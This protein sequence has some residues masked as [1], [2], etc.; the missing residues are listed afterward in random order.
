MYIEDSIRNIMQKLDV[1]SG[2][3]SLNQ[4]IASLKPIVSQYLVKVPK[5][6]VI[7]FFNKIRIQNS[8]YTEK[9]LVVN[10]ILP[11]DSEHF[12]LH[13]DFRAPYHDAYYIT[14]FKDS[15]LHLSIEGL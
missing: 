13:V 7:E 10:S 1:M 9:A 3:N 11:L 12:G 6:N 2:D 14:R 15:V 5:T 4:N 8:N